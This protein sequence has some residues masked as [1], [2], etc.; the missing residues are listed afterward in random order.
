MIVPTFRDLIEIMHRKYWG[1]CSVKVP[2]N[3]PDY[4][5]VPRLAEDNWLYFEGESQ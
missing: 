2:H 5:M 1:Q 4:G 3:S